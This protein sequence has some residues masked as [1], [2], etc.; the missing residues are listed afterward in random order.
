MKSRP[1]HVDTRPVQSVAESIRDN[2]LRYIQVHFYSDF[3]ATRFYG[4]R[5]LL[6]RFVVLWP[7]IWLKERGI[8]LPAERYESILVGGGHPKGILVDAATLG[9]APHNPVKYLATVVQSHFSVHGETYYEEGKALRNKL[10]PLLAALSGRNQP[11][12]ADPIAPMATAAS[13]LAPPKRRKS[14]PKP[15]QLEFL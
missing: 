8:T 13:L 5:K 11:Q 14:A 3:P 2:V 9:Q 4:D 15:S 10:D 7:A 12:S 1:L 6:L